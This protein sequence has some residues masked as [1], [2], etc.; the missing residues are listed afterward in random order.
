MNTQRTQDVDPN[1]RINI[2]GHQFMFAGYGLENI[3]I[4]QLLSFYICLSVCISV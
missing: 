4:F 1:D 3:A 2:G